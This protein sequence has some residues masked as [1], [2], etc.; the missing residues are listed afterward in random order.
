M[1]RTLIYLAK[2]HH[3]WKL[4][5]LLVSNWE[6]PFAVLVWHLW[7]VRNGRMEEED[8]YG[9]KLSTLPERTLNW[10][11]LLMSPPAWVGTSLYDS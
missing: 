10:G 4:G 11:Q 7:V 1:K 6:L 9:V 5:L 2:H 8:S 3:S